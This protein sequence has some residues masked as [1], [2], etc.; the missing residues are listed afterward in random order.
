MGSI[1]ID[2]KE[3]GH[4]EKQKCTGKIARNLSSGETDFH[5]RIEVAGSGSPLLTK[6]D[7]NSYYKMMTQSPE[8]DIMTRKLH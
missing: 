7:R 8:M 6:N 5:F 4:R 3:S 2:S 1:Y